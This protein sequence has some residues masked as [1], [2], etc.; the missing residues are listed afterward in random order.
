MNITK[1]DSQKSRGLDETAKISFSETNVIKRMN[2]LR[3]IFA[4]LILLGHCSMEFEHEL[5]PLM[6]IHKFNMVSVCFF[7]IVSGWS[8]S[9]NFYN[10][11]NYLKGF[12]INKAFKLFMFAFV[13]EIV[14]RLLNLIFLDKAVIV[15]WGLILNYNLYIYEMI[16][17]Y[18]AF[19]IAHKIKWGKRVRLL[20]LLVISIIIS[21]VCV[22]M[23]NNYESFWPHSTHFS[24]LCFVWGI[25]LH[26]YYDY[27][28]K[29]T[30]TIKQSIFASAILII[31]GLASCICLKMPSGSFIGGCILHNL[32]GIC[33]LSVIP[34]WAYY[35]DYTKI[36]IIGHLTKYST[37]IYLYQFIVLSIVVAKY[38]VYN[39]KID[40]SYVC[41][42][43]LIT[44]LLA[45]LMHFVNKMIS[46]VIN[47]VKS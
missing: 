15:N 46:G 18:I 31:V 19:Y 28:V 27:F 42:V 33:I 21:I 10:K 36:P 45:I 39:K 25:L 9:Y 30:R 17:F 26:E 20:F 11:D 23:S 7:F 4:L 2:H 29:L 12:L 34:I 5:L 6:V 3:G 13:C 32:V 35:I 16:V 37:E 22:Y 1:K 41:I 38:Q 14:S 8:L 47:K 43:V 40:L 24:S 44:V